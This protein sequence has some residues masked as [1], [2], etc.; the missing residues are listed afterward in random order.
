LTAHF[1]LRKSFDCLL[2]NS[3]SWIN[4]R[5]LSQPPITESSTTRVAVGLSPIRRLHQYPTS[6]KALRQPAERD[7]VRPALYGI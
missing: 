1:L 7:P 4:H 3:L 2:S 5:T 6:E